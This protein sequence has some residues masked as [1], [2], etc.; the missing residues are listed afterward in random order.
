MTEHTKEFIEQ[1]R[2][3]KARD[4]HSYLVGR[5]RAFCDDS[6]CSAREINIKIKTMWGLPVSIQC[7][8]CGK[9]PVINQ[10][11]TYDRHIA[12]DLEKL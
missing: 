12:R 7:P 10:I 4:P 6:K 1:L 5:I 3:A 9:E 11:E 8:L 2:S